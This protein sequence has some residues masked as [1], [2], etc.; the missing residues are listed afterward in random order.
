MPSTPSASCTNAPNFVMLVTGPSITVP[1]AN[2][3]EAP[4]P[5]I[6]E[7][8][9][10]AEGDAALGG[11]HSK[12]DGFDG[13]ADFDQVA[14]VPDSSS[15]RTFRKYESGPS[16]PG[17]SSTKAPKSM[18][19]VTG[20]AHAFASFVFSGNRIPRMRL[21]LLHA[22]RDPLLLRVDLDDLRFD[23]LARGKHVGRLVY[24]MPR[25]FSDV[26][27]S[28]GATDVHECAVVGEAAHFALHRVAFLEFAKRRCLAGRLF[29]FG[30]DAAIDHH[31]FVVDIELD[32]AATDF[33]LDELRQ[34]GGIAVPLREAGMKART[35]TST[36]R[37]PLTHAS[38]GADDGRL[39]RE[40]LL[41]RLPSR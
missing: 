7:R 29:V 26:Q 14:G 18:R 27:Q 23:L 41:Q 1:G 16:M 2:F 15:P 9:L 31:V 20:A 12:N 37:P 28:V 11:V 13:F 6:A 33:L 25:N 21:K 30:N 17:S 5:G 39:F 24:A 19:R 36:L 3:S 22:D 38:H 4:H 8:L 32:D 10:Q 34:F 40:R 35:P